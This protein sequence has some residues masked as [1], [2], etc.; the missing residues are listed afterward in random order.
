L[1][2]KAI[3]HYLK[4]FQIAFNVYECF[5]YDKVLALQHLLAA[6]KFELVFT[7]NNSQCPARCKSIFM[8]FF[9]PKLQFTRTLSCEV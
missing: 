8:D 2:S 5:P 4:G 7:Q 6:P 1:L 3:L 9:E